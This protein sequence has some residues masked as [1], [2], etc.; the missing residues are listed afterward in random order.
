MAI[1]GNIEATYNICP[2]LG[3]GIGLG[4]KIF[5]E[6]YF[7]GFVCLRTFGKPWICN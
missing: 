5:G 2:A 3:T 1:F 7:I 6:L 4:L